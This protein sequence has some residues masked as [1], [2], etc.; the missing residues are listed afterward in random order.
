MPFPGHGY[1]FELAEVV[2]C[3]RS[4]LVESPSMTLADTLGVARTMD[5]LRACWTPAGAAPR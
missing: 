2:R 3:L 1:Q 5:R 4:G